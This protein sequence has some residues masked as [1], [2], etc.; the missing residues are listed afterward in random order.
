MKKKTIFLQLICC[1]LFA[2]VAVAQHTAVYV[3]EDFSKLLTSHVSPYLTPENGA[4]VALNVRANDTFGSLSKRDDM[5]SYGTVGSFA[6]TSLHRYY[7]A[8]DTAIMMATG[9]DEIVSGNDS[10]GAFTTLKDGLTDGARW[11]WVTYKDLAIG[12]NGTDNCQKYDGHT[13]TTA[14][15]DGSRTA[16]NLTAN[17]GAPFAELNT[18]TNLDASSWY[19]YKVAY[20]D[21]TTYSYST[22]K[23]NPIKTGAAVYNVALTGIPLGDTGT[24]HRYIYRTLG[25]ANRTTVEADTTY[26]WVATIADNTTTTLADTVTDATADDNAAPTWSTASAGTNITPPAAKYAL[27]HK[28]RLFLANKAS[29]NSYI[30]W[31]VVFNPEWYDAA[32]YD[33]LRVDDGDDITFL[34]EILGK[35]VIGKTNTITNFDTR[36]SDDSNW[37]FFT[38]SFI[39]CPAPFTA[40]QSPAGIIYLGWDGLYLYNGETSKLISDVVTPE[41][42]DILQ[43]NLTNAVGVFFEGEYSFAYASVASGESINNR[44]LVFDTVRNAYTIDEKEVN[45]FAKW[46]S[47]ND[48]GTLYTGSSDTDGVVRGYTTDLTGYIV[49]YKT[50]FEEGTKDSL[51]Y[52]GTQNE[53][54]VEI[55]WG[56]FIDDTTSI[57]Q[58]T[59]MGQITMDAVTFDAATINRPGTTA[60]WW[61]PAIPVD[62]DSYDKLYWNETL[63]AYGNITFAIRSAATAAAVVENN[64]DWSSEFSTPTGS[65]VSSETAND[66][67]QLRST[68]TTTDITYSPV[69]K[70][71]DNYAIKLVYSK[72]GEAAETSINS[73]W[74]SGFHDFESPTIPKRIW[75]INVFYE[76]TSGTMTVGLDNERG[77]IDQ[78]F[79]IDLSIDPGLT[80]TDQYF[81]TSLKKIYKWQAPINSETD[82]TPIGR[83]WKFS[84][85][86]GGIVDWNVYNITIKYSPDEYYDD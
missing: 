41:I 27:I 39:G 21:G 85:V 86:E 42:R 20:Y 69:L 68:F 10:T 84:V 45:C 22:A 57:I 17:L 37:Q 23:S 54:E 65:D 25:A 53:P 4:T 82:P 12:C 35:I 75:G 78:S 14:N 59:T 52:G 74:E 33:Y 19:Q 2:S 29:Y 36:D 3:I 26:Y 50:D 43:S 70:T 30:Y 73:V 24:T 77:D 8:D 56:I 11:T 38:W 66:W 67:A 79:T 13:Q 18:G 47:G 16:D 46:D 49:R 60:Y 64:L 55:G 15:T 44:V 32:D 31:S 72:V 28:E 58:N 81:G 80:D 83:K 61:S 6:V 5:L 48:Y 34:K 9:S 62:A 1:I 63:G 51:Y 76:G 7:Q 71:L 40:V